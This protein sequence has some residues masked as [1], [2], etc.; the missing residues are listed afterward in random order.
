MRLDLTT[1]TG[2]MA[3]EFLAFLQNITVS[4][5]SKMCII[6]KIILELNDFLKSYNNN[7]LITNV[8]ELQEWLV[9]IEM[10]ENTNIV[11]NILCRIQN[12][13]QIISKLVLKF[14]KLLGIGFLDYQD[15]SWFKPY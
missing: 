2:T 6:E 9:S 7:K 4:R 11:W 5:F 14:K 15:L 13:D 1:I 12:N 10:I 8:V 3:K